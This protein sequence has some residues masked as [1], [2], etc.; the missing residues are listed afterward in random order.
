MGSVK[1]DR[2][3]NQVFKPCKAL[4]IRTQ[5]RCDWM[6]RQM[7]QSHQGEILEIGC[8]TGELSFFLA[9]KTNFYVLGTDLCAPFIDQA[10]LLYQRQ[11]LKFRVLDFKK[12]L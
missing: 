2:G 4:T 9:E 5:R 7:D 1:D 12:P 10:R 8:G 11:N 6:I 3:Y